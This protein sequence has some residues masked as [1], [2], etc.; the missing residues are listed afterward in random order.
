MKKLIVSLLMVGGVS[1]ALAQGTVGFSTFNAANPLLGRTFLV[2]GVTGAGSAY[3]GQLYWSSSLAGT[4]TAIGAPVAF[5]NTQ[6]GYIFGPQVTVPAPDGI[7][8]TALFFTMRVWNS[9][10]GADWNT[11][12][13]A[14][15]GQNPLLTQYGISGG[16]SRSLG[17]LDP[18]GGPPFTPGTYNNFANFSLTAVPEP[19]VIALA[20]LGLASLVVFRRRN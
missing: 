14:V 17:G 12:V 20:G 11:A 8:G 18:D 5:D 7:P 9:A 3:V 16:K 10:A 6:L 13:G 15:P 2:D 1:V 4:Y 19:S